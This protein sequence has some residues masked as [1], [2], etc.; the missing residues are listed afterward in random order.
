[1]GTAEVDGAVPSNPNLQG[2][3]EQEQAPAQP[4][5]KRISGSPPPVG[6]HK[7]LVFRKSV[8]R[9]KRTIGYF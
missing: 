8:R 3:G 4:K 7:M 1:M 5:P 9:V 6:N 2:G